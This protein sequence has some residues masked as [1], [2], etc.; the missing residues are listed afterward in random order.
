M[1]RPLS[2][3]LSCSTADVHE[4]DKAWVPLMLEESYRP[5]GWLGI[6]CVGP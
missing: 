1:L 2:D 6:M 5:N 3:A 4:Q